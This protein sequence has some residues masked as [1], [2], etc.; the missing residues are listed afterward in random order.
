MTV[1]DVDVRQFVLEHLT[2]LALR[3]VAVEQDGALLGQPQAV[4]AVEVSE[5]NRD[6]PVGGQALE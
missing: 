6:P 3:Q 2:R 5:A 4:H 1:I